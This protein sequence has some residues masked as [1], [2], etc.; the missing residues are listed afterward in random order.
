MALKGSEKEF[1]VGWDAE[2][3]AISLEKNTP[4]TIVGGESQI[5][6]TVVAEATPNLSSTYLDGEAYGFMSY[7]INDN[8]YFKLRDLGDAFGFSVEWDADTDSIHISTTNA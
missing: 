4:Y 2:K 1:N 6:S 5:G 7:T 3:S 8:N